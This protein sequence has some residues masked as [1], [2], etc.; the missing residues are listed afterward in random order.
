MYLGQLSMFLGLAIEKNKP[1]KN[2][3]NLCHRNL[4]KN[5]STVQ[6]QNSCYMWTIQP[7]KS[8]FYFK[9]RPRYIIC[10]FNQEQ[11]TFT[12]FETNNTGL[13]DTN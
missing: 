2:D 7:G 10:G 8:K 13:L 12:D 5:R 6:K 9:N 11:W 1:P 3:A 4:I